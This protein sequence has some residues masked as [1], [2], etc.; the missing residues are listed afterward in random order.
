[1]KVPNDEALTDPPKAAAPVGGAGTKRPITVIVTDPVWGE[2][3]G[4]RESGDG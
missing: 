4:N 3:L 1:M 2:V